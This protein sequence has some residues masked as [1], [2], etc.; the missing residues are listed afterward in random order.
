MA[1]PARR[2]PACNANGIYCVYV[3]G[4]VVE[5]HPV[6]SFGPWPDLQPPLHYFPLATMAHAGKN[7]AREVYP[8]ARCLVGWTQSQFT[9]VRLRCRQW[10]PH[11]C[12]QVLV[13]PPNVVANSTDTGPLGSKSTNS[14]GRAGGASVRLRGD[15]RGGRR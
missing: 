8:S 4:N 5:C 3:S 15:D 10:R 7:L 2:A 11:G 12:S 13:L 6:K 9:C 14:T 1:R